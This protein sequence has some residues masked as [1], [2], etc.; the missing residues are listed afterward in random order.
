MQ[1][2]KEISVYKRKGSVW[3]QRVEGDR[4]RGLYIC[5]PE[6]MECFLSRSWMIGGGSWFLTERMA[7][8]ARVT[9]VRISADVA[10]MAV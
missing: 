4:F 9:S 8:I 6:L 5:E 7:D 3:N 2:R 10:P 1:Q